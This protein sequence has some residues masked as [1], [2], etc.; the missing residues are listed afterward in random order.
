MR[1]SM[2]T[3][4]VIDWLRGSQ[5]HSPDTRNHGEHARSVTGKH[6]LLEFLLKSFFLGLKVLEAATATAQERLRRLGR[7]WKFRSIEIIAIYT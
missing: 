4:T 2:E 6:S 5:A 7:A 1:Q 3:A